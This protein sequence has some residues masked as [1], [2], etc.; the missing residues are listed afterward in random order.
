VNFERASGILLHPT[1]LPGPYG[2]GDLGQEAY[3]FVD[4][5][6]AAGQTLWQILPVA[7]TGYGDS[8]Y[9]AF[10]AFAGNPLLLSPDLLLDGGLLDADDLRDMPDF[11]ADRVD[12][13]AV[14]AWKMAVLRRSYERSKGSAS[15]RS[16]L[17]SLA[18]ENAGWLGDYALFMAVKAAH[19]GSDWNDWEEG[20]ALRRPESLAHWRERVADDVGFQTYIQILFLKQWFAVK[21]YANERGVR[22]V[23]DIPIFVAYDSADVWAHPDLFALDARGRPTVVAGVPPDYFS[24]TGQYW[25]N[26]LYRWDVMAE[27]GYAWWVERF[28]NAFRL[29]DVVRLDHFRGFAAYWEVPV[30]DERTAVNGRWVPGPGE[31]FFAAVREALGERPII[32]ED[33]GL[34]TPD[35]AALREAVGVPGMRVLQFAFGGPEVDPTN[36]Y[37]PHNFDRNTVVYTGTHDNDTTLAWYR[38][39]PEQERANVKQYLGIDAG[40]E[41][42]DMDAMGRVVT[43]TLIRAALGSVANMAIVPLQDLLELG[44]EARMNMPG[45]SGGNWQWRYWAGALTDDVRDRLRELTVLYARY[46]PDTE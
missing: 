17:A 39:A 9:A 31:P 28:R 38:A 26:P 30:N 37:L 5:L 42:E 35:V 22:I 44:H 13:G 10:S 45:R 46:V 32:A 16:D 41:W 14:F 19:G 21:Q 40:G 27:D 43:R 20:I 15:E 2:I 6:A 11:P 8:P 29:Y 1:S 36:L 3:R 7:P 24:A 34:I 18:E 4:F 25:G 33:L 23:G 12:Y